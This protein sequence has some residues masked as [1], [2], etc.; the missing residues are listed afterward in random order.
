[1]V[2]RILLNP[3]SYPPY[4]SLHLYTLGVGDI[5]AEGALKQLGEMARLVH[6]VSKLLLYCTYRYQS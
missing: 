2:L 6:Q 3:S 4:L 5:Q 1:M